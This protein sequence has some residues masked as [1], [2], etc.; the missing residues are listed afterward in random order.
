MQYE[1]V[2][3]KVLLLVYLQTQ[4]TG[5]AGKTERCETLLLL[6]LTFKSQIQNILYFST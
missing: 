5:F 6:P 1:S 2:I 3:Q 4:P